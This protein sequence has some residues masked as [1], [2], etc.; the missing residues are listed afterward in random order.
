VFSDQ[1]QLFGLFPSVGPR[2]S[3]APFVVVTKR[4]NTGVMVIVTRLDTH[5]NT[6][7]SRSIGVID[8]AIRRPSWVSVD[9]VG[10]CTRKDGVTEVI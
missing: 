6:A 3:T 7:G 8:P 5:P 1:I 4:C 9:G 2:T 10:H